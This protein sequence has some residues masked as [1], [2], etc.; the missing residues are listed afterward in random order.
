MDFDQLSQTRGILRRLDLH[1]LIGLLTEYIVCDLPM[2]GEND[3][4]LA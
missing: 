2:R 4:T 3:A 1:V